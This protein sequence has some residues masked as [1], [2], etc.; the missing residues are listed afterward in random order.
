MALA[1]Y[2]VTDELTVLLGLIAASVFL[3]RNLY[4]PQSLVHPILLGRQSDVSRVRNPGESAVYR[5]YG[6]GM[7]GRL[8][9]R[10]ANNVQLITDLVK[11]DFDSPRTLW[12]TKVTNAQLK[13]RVAA[14][15]TGLI[16]LANLVPGESNVLLLLN[17]SLEFILA[18]L[19]LASHAI[20]S[21]TLSSLALLSPVLD[22]HSPSAI[23]THAAFL[24][25][26]LELLCDARAQGEAHTVIA[27][28]TL[29]ATL[30]L[31][32]APNVTVLSWSDVESAGVKASD[33]VAPSTVGPEDVFTVS[34]YSTPSGAVR[35]AHFT[36]QNITAGVAAT[37]ALLPPNALLSALDTV[38]SAHALSSGIGRALA[39]TAIYE[40][41]SFATLA[42]T[43]LISPSSTK[44]DVADLLSATSLPLPSPTVLF[45]TPA[46][47]RALSTAILSAA[48]ASSPLAAP[49]ATRHKLA[50]LAE[51]FV[52][53][54]SLW[55][56]LV[57][58]GARVG[59]MGAGA[60]TVRAVIA[61]NRG[62]AATDL[63]PARLALSVPFVHAHAHPL[64]AAPVFASH[65]LD[66]QAFDEP[67]S[68]GS[69]SAHVGPPSANVEAKL[70]RVDEAELASGADPVG[71]V[72]VRGPAVGRG[73]GVGEEGEVAGAVG[74]E[75][76]GEEGWVETGERGR[77]LTNG[78]FK[79]W[80]A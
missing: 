7:L 36:H 67:S 56:R 44:L 39:Y 31:Q 15:G 70:V 42:S 79:V 51:G 40:G 43:A 78:T 69:G 9:H 63:T 68:G 60:G 1:D 10:P 2:V 16:R 18:D 47:A 77:V 76:G 37:R 54:D 71:D 13:A 29:P 6:T 66:L 22:L 58:D 61:L 57:F 74:T 8:P 20:P 17:D 48:A 46:H 12:S 35:S 24:P 34:F 3:L 64:V 45:V 59:V 28:G 26:L 27:L 23:I 38:L 73:V 52:T 72:L 14:L 80:T 21:F 55:D 11:T 41:T 62:L 19:A 50:A 25:Q 65:A 33:K 49:L 4:K 5:N 32:R 75:T 53:R 30:D